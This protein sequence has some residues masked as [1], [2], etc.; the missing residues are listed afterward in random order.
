MLVEGLSPGDLKLS[1]DDS[2]GY[3]RSAVGLPP[4][5]NM[6]AYFILTILV[7]S[8]FCISALQLGER[9]SEDYQC[10]TQVSHLNYVRSDKLIIDSL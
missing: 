1:A 8:F 5:Y 6:P 7:Q 9:C 10:K 2:Q 3:L 4:T